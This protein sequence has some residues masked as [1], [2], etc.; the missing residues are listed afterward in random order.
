[1]KNKWSNCHQTYQERYLEQVFLVLPSS[2]KEQHN[3]KNSD[4]NLRDIQRW[5]GQEV[6]ITE[7]E[8][9]VD[10]IGLNDEA[11]AKW[12]QMVTVAVGLQRRRL[13]PNLSARIT[14]RTQHL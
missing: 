10:G 11:A 1:M 9:E 4:N 3:I 12:R 2:P 5:I 8:S 14:F 7:D 6:S 13:W